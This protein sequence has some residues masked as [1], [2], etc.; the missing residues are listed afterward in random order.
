V[1]PAAS[2]SSLLDDEFDL[3]LI[4]E[5]AGE[6]ALGSDAGLFDEPEP[7]QEQEAVPIAV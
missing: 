1:A 6:A 7:E 2:S 4:T 5:D 3:P